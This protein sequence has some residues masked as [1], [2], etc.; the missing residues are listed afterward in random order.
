[1]AEPQAVELRVD[2][3]HPV[4]PLPAGTDLGQRLGIVVLLRSHEAAQ[5]VGVVRVRHRCALLRRTPKLSRRGRRKELCLPGKP[6]WRPR[7]AA[8]GCSA[9]WGRHST[10]DPCSPYF[11]F[12]SRFPVMSNSC[13]WP[14][15]FAPP[16]P[17][18]V[19]PSIVS[20]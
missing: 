11:S 4:R 14:P 8:A 17:L 5:V 15:K 2:V 18:S 7:S 19:S 3:P 16:F 6:E 12:F 10:P 1:R 20:V 13:F 9:Y